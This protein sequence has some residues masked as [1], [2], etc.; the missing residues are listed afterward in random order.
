MIGN[1]ATTP[2]TREL[3]VSLPGFAHNL[4]R[5]QSFPEVS[6]SEFRLDG[7]LSGQS[8]TMGGLSGLPVPRR[9]PAVIGS[10]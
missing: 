8:S 10:F 6:N 2:E 9:E 3:A 1:M 5:S 4:T 7:R